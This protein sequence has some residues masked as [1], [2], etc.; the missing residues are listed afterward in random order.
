MHYWTLFLAVAFAIG[1]RSEVVIRNQQ[2]DPNQHQIA[3]ELV[4][5]TK[6]T[7]TAWSVIPVTTRSDG[8]KATVRF[9]HDYFFVVGLVAQGINVPAEQRPIAPG[10][11]RKLTVSASSGDGK[12][13]K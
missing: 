3:F 9:L 1:A 12:N 2:Y 10:E 7:V 4:N 13:V 5:N 11:V 8:S 6:A